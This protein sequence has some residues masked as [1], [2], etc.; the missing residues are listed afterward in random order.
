M[1]ASTVEIIRKKRDG[2]PLEK[3]EIAFM[4]E[5]L[6]HGTVTEGQIAAS[7][8]LSCDI[9]KRNRIVRDTYLGFLGDLAFFD[10]QGEDDPY[11]TGLG[12]RWVLGYLT[13]ADLAG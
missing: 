10:L 6:T 8:K 9:V 5:G 13:T 7:A 2:H 4:V 11:Y 3:A 12:D 1:A